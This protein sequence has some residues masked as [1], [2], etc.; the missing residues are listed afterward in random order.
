MRLVYTDRVSRR[1]RL[2]VAGV[3]CLGVARCT[4]TES[5]GTPRYFERVV[6]IAFAPR[7]AVV[8]CRVDAWI[9]FSA[10]RRVP[11]P[12]SVAADLR[13]RG[14]DVLHG[15]P[16]P[17]AGEGERRRVEWRRG[18]LSADARRALDFALT[19]AASAVESSACPGGNAAR[20]RAAVLA[21]LGRPTT[22]YTYQFESDTGEVQPEA[23]EF[24]ILDLDEG[25]LYELVEFN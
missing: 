22:F 25:V 12:P 9:D 24:R 3:L 15:H 14:A 18:P 16:L 5:W 23:L 21:G 7:G 10:F 11:L 6:G 4:T 17:G 2:A 8:N 13:A 1:L 19:G 20:M